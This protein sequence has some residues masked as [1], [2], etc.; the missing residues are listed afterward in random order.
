MGKHKK[1]K[2]QEAPSDGTPAAGAPPPAAQP[3]I[4]L[5]AADVATTV[6]T[7]RY[8]ASRPDVLASKAL[9]ELRAALHPIVEAQLKKYDPVDYVSRVTAALRTGHAADAL[10]ALQ[11]LLR[12]G[13]TARQGTVQR[14]VRDCDSIS[15]PAMRARLLHTVLRAGKPLEEGGENGNGGE[16]GEGGASAAGPS[17][18]F[19]DGEMEEEAGDDDDDEEEDEGDGASTPKRETAVTLQQAVEILPAWLPGGESEVHS[20]E[21]LESSA[22]HACGE[23]ATPRVILDRKALGLRVVMSELGPDRQPPNHHDLH[24]YSLAPNSVQLLET[25]ATERAAARRVDVPGVPG[26][27]VMLG[28]LSRAECAKLT[29]VAD[30]I[31]YTPD[32]PLSR[33]DPSGIGGLELLLGDETMATLLSRCAGLLPAELCGGALAGINARCRFFRYTDAERAVYR[34][35]IDGSWPGAGLDALTGR[36]V[37]DAFGDRRSRLTFLIC[38]SSPSPSPLPSP[39]PSSAKR[40]TPVPHADPTLH[41]TMS[42]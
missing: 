11:G 33:A 34:P 36:Y 1:R 23:A 12:R 18:E 32:H 26:A 9:R 21:Q 10:L 41:E 8:L 6:Q 30:A 20:S 17:T 4:Q 38:A 19:G 2:R 31:G 29:A 35:H 7:L 24:I 28:V 14:W 42:P 15:D 3:V 5:R 13:Q 25:S 40:G 16:G 37:H 39:L 22:P 27:F